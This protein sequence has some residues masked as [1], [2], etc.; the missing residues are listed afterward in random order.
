MRT[1]SVQQGDTTMLRTILMT[2]V[3]TAAVSMGTMGTAWAKISEPDVIFSGT[4]INASDGSAV[5][6][7]LNGTASPMAT[8][9]MG[10][11]LKYVLR[12]AMD[13]FEPRTPGTA[14]TGDTAEIFINGV[15]A[16]T[17]VI[18]KFGSIVN[19][20]LGVQNLEQWAKD[21]PGD[22]GSGDMNRNGVSDLQDYLDGKDPA[23]CVWNQVDASH[24]ETTVYHPLVLKNC[25][26]AAG[27]DQKHNLIRV[28]R[29]SYAGNFSYTS[30][31]GEAY[32]LTLIGGYDPAGTAERSA[33]PAL[34]ILSGDTDNDGIGNGVVLVV[35]DA[36]KTFGKVHIESLTVKNGK[37][38]AGQNGGGIQARI[39]QGELELVG[40]I[41]SGNTAD[42]GGGLSVESSDR[43]TIFLTNNV[44]YGNSAANAAAVRIVST[45]TGSVTLLNNT[46]ADNTSTAEADGR[47]LLI[48]S[49]LASV[50]M[51]NNI[52]SGVSGVTGKDIY[53]NSLGAA[54]PLS[55]TN[56]ALDAANGMLVNSPGFVPD[57]GTIGDAP[58]FAAP[59]TGNY[60]LSLESPCIDRG[61]AHA[62]LPIEYPVAAWTWA[63]MNS[64]ASL[65]G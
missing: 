32:D 15:L 38:P 33:D 36:S 13:A 24:A 39:Y 61:F 5:T 56:N 21:H 58:L 48:K 35:D 34:T 16:A 2:I 40:N 6:I 45:A 44:L 57:A 47:S 59:L 26:A 63:L 9:M 12:V 14:V 18:P 43:G 29:G 25:L 55:I 41:I 22:N 27:T 23:S 7:K 46:L 60:Q 52:I 51:T 1:N 8:F 42:S 49:T 3:M 17:A 11:G 65:P 62:K 64:P 28:A 4:A 50:D 30:G 31:W 54:V 37:A 10:S 20:N 19:L 53:I